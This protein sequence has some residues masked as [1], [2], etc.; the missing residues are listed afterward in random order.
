MTPVCENSEQEINRREMSKSRVERAAELRT[1]L[2]VELALSLAYG[3]AGLLGGNPEVLEDKCHN[4][5]GCGNHEEVFNCTL[6]LPPHPNHLREAFH[7]LLL[8]GG[9]IYFSTQN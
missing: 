2:A 5:Q 7:T 9:L 8:R 4:Y 6:R 1:K 3:A